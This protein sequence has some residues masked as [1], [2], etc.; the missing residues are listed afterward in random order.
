V[1]ELF[2]ISPGNYQAVTDAHAKCKEQITTLARELEA[3]REALALWEKFVYYATGK[4][5]HSPIELPLWC[6]VVFSEA[7]KATRAA[8]IAAQDGEV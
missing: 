5:G 6:A 8:A 1:S 7:Y 4:S 3:A 2:E